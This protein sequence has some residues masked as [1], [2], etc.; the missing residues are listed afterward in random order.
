MKAS[1]RRRLVKLAAKYQP[2]YTPMEIAMASTTR[3]LAIEKRQAQLDAIRA[4]LDNLKFADYPTEQDWNDVADAPNLL[5]T[6]IAFGWVKDPD[7]LM[8]DAVNGMWRAMERVR[9]GKALRLD[10][11]GLVAIETV[12][13]D[14]EAH[15]AVISE[16]NALQAQTVTHEEI[17]RAQRGMKSKRFAERIIV[18]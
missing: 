10:A 12:I 3:P 5:D 1:T 17:W 15:L 8:M 2:P 7:G 18:Q 4:A 6:F 16:R 11:D 13:D 9:S 14:Y